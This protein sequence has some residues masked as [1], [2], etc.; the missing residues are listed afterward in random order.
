MKIESPSHVIDIR[1]Q[2]D[3]TNYKKIQLFDEYRGATANAV[4]FMILFR[5]REIKMVFDGDEIS[6]SKVT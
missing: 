2:V 6:E 4:L 5:H 1:I 3:H